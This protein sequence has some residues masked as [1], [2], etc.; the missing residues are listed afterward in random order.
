MNNPYS[1]TYKMRDHLKKDHP[2]EYADMLELLIA[3]KVVIVPD[4]PAGDAHE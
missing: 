4:N 2:R 1:V 3:G